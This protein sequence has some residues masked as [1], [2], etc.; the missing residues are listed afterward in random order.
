MTFNFITSATHLLNTQL[1]WSQSQAVNVTDL[2]IQSF[3]LKRVFPLIISAM[4]QPTDQMSTKRKKKKSISE[5]PS[6]MHYNSILF[7]TV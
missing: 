3:P 6:Q 2:R 5:N 7:S 1:H 4:M